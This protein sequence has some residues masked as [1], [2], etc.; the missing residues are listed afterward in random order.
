MCLGFDPTLKS[1]VNPR[2]S[3]LDLDGKTV[4]FG[5][6]DVE[7]VKKGAADFKNPVE[8]YVNVKCGDEKVSVVVGKSWSME[9]FKQVLMRVL[10]RKELF[11][12][13]D[14]KPIPDS[15][16]LSALVGKVVEVD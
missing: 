5:S 4:Y 7:P 8:A 3:L 16:K 15:T 6:P 2:Q 1:K 11:L 12:K 14:G 10:C 13:L 9:Q